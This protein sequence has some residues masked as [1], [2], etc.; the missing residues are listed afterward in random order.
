MAIPKAKT[1]GHN[2]K[3]KYNLGGVANSEMKENGDGECRG[4]QNKKKLK[5]EKRI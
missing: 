4:K 5:I 3:K 1:R 2:Y